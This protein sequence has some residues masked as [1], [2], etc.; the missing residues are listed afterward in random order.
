MAEHS[1]D[2]RATGS[3]PTGSPAHE[4]VHL[5]LSSPPRNHGHTTAA[6]TTVVL[7]L[8]GFTVSALAVT[9]ALVWLFW[10]G[11]GVILLGV[12]AGKV[13]QILGHGQGGA[14]TLAKQARS[15]H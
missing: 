9:F 4:V 13:L 5:P 12:V 8:V 10:A 14:A 2:R 11:M 7:V 1:V 6:W 15:T 3:T